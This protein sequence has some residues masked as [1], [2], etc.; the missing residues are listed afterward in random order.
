MNHPLLTIC[1]PV[2]NNEKTIGQTIES[3]L[4]QTYENFE[5]LVS[6]NGSTDG[7]LN[8]VNS[9]NSP[10]ISVRHNIKKIKTDKPYI[11]SYDNYNGCLESGLIKGELVAFYHGDD[12]YENDI[13]QKEVEFLVQHPSAGAVF[14]MGKMINENGKSAG[15]HKVP[16]TLPQKDS[17]QLEEILKNLLLHGNTF[18]LTPTFM[19]KKRIFE[20][21]GIFASEGKFGTSA[22]LEMW[23]R[24]LKTYDIGILREN[25]IRRRI[26]GGGKLYGLNRVKVADYFNVMDHFLATTSFKI[27]K[28][29]KDQYA[30]QKDFDA[31]LRA[32]NFLMKGEIGKAKELITNPLPFLWPYFENMTLIRTK[33]L[34]LKIILYTGIN[35]GLGRYLGKIL[36][37][38][39]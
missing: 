1:I 14:T 39:N 23:L 4:N 7:T 35:L 12:V 22:D 25:L 20:N 6:D 11:G 17:Y 21:I 36:Y 32:L 34:V 10:K 26:G 24:I 29:Y 30:Y 8:V 18:L 38:F 28:K 19:V 9:F 13:A 31:T 16:K 5:V 3:I 27:E 15:H 2:Y 37:R 33:V